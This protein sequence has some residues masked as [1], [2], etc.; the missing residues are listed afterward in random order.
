MLSLFIIFQWE[1]EGERGGDGR[2]EGGKGECLPGW[3]TFVNRKDT[4]EVAELL[5]IM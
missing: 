3:T 1:G 2:G 5:A 4:I